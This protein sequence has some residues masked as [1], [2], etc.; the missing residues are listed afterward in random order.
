[1]LV[2]RSRSDEDF[3]TCPRAG[4]AEDDPAVAQEVFGPLLKV[5]AAAPPF[6]A[7]RLANGVEQAAASVWGSGGGATLVM[8]QVY[9]AVRYE[10][11]ATRSRL[12]SCRTVAGAGR[13]GHRSE[14]AGVGEYQRRKTITVRLD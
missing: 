12:L 14:C 8:A 7:V 5:Q 6:D 10:S 4:V 11:T 9:A 13:A 2:T 1:V 3:L